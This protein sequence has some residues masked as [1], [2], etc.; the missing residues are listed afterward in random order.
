VAKLIHDGFYRGHNIDLLFNSLARNAGARTIGVVLSGLM[1]DGSQGLAALKEAGGIALVQSPGEAGV[2]EMPRSAIEFDG[3][4]DKV[5]PIEALAR[6]I[7]R[8]VRP[9]AG[10]RARAAAESSTELLNP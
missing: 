8:L 1:K 10:A 9:S 4:V 6:E 7:C 2:K 3:P 5:A